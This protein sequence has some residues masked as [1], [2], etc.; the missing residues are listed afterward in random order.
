M[1]AAWTL[2]ALRTS[3]CAALSIP[4]D[5]PSALV[6]ADIFSYE[7]RWLEGKD[8]G[9]EKTLSEI[10]NRCGLDRY[11][12]LEA[13][14]QEGPYEQELQRCNAEAEADGVFGFPFFV[15]KGHKF[16][17]N[18]RIEWLVQEILKHR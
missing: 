18:D 1:S 8:I 11:A 16:W 2:I 3:R 15:Y 7:A 13:I 4:W 5:K 9:N 14:K 10:A 6:L 12:F 17:G